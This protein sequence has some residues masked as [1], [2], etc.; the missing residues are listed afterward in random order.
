MSRLMKW[1]ETYNFH[2]RITVVLK[3]EMHLKEIL[4]HLEEV[5]ACLR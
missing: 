2:F 3:G 1:K 4:M 5:E